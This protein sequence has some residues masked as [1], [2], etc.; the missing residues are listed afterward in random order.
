MLLTTASPHSLSRPLPSSALITLPEDSSIRTIRDPANV[1]QKAVYKRPD[2]RTLSDSTEE[3]LVVETELN[4]LGTV[5]ESITFELPTNVDSRQ[6]RSS[7]ELS[8]T[9]GELR[10]AVRLQARRRKNE[11]DAQMPLTFEH[12]DDTN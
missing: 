10:A 3:L 11:S 12:S 1:P 6:F 5:V 4:R 2:H 8:R 9:G 7:I